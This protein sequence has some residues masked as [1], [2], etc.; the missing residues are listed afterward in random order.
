MDLLQC[1]QLIRPVIVLGHQETGSLRSIVPGL[2]LH[3]H[4]RGIAVSQLIHRSMHLIVEVA[5]RDLDVIV[6]IDL[7]NIDSIE[8]SIP[9]RLVHFHDFVVLPMISVIVIDG[10]LPIEPNF[11]VILNLELLIMLLTIWLI[12][13]LRALDLLVH[14]HILACEMIVKHKVVLLVVVTSCELSRSLLLIIWLDHVWR[15]EWRI[16]RHFF[17]LFFLALKAENVLV[18]DLIR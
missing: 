6:L 12:G 9:H 18:V 4:R 5:S 2:N 15:L 17:L 10:L 7:V 13:V 14:I 3:A 16:L 8:D 11:V 1:D